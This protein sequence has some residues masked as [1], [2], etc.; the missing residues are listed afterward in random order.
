MAVDAFVA[1]T[2]KGR[3]VSGMGADARDVDNDG[4]PDIFETAMVTETMPFFHNLGNN[5]F[6][7]QTYT[8]GLAS[9]TSRKSGW[10]NGIFDFNNDGW[11]DLF[12]ACGDVMDADGFFAVRVPQSNSI[13]ANLRNG[14]FQDVSTTAG[15]DFGQKAIHRGAAFGDIDNDGRVDVVVTA[16]N[17][18]LEVWRNVSPVPNH[19][20][21]LRL[22]GAKSN[23]DGSGAKIK[24][25]AASG[26]QYNH[27][28]TAVG[29]GCAS[30]RRVHFGLG[31]DS[32]IKEIQILWP[33]GTVQT[34]HNVKADQIVTV[35]EN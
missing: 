15:T 19:W 8:S 28:N 24:I 10:S 34:L 9:A 32:E 18:P 5:L 31:P 3:A 23:R 6:E 26:T 22:I 21:L 7:E 33:S 30:D 4:L 20:I 25:V 17:G 16:L 11:K 2:D 27:V 29:Y 14:R 13:F 12:A 1:Y 35:K